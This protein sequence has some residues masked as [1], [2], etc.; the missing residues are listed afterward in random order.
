M[1]QAFASERSTVLVVDDEMQL[2]H[3][4]ERVMADEGYR[5]LTAADGMEALA[6]LQRSDSKVDLVITDVRMP[7]M[8][9]P[10]LAAHL[11]AQVL[12][13][14]VLFVSGGHTF[15]DVPG[16]MLR[17]PFLPDDLSAMV[18]SLIA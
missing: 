9:G 15:G 12:P 3:Y 1:R 16:P 7:R 18:R 6:L 2:R 17:K 5:V 4:M 11:A 10:E 13:P 14:P 8:S